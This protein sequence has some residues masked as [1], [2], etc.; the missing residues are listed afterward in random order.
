MKLSKIQAYFFILLAMMGICL[1]YQGIWLISGSTT[2]EIIK[3]GKGSG[4][5]YKHI[6]NVTVRYIVKNKSYTDTYL[7]NGLDYGTGTVPIKYLLFAPSISR[8]DNIIG[9]WGLVTVVFTIVFFILSIS[10]LIQDIVP[11]GSNFVFS[12]AYPFLR[13]KKP[14]TRLDVN[15]QYAW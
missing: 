15:D 8:Q 9:N 1:L 7:R 2:G 6:D 11:N 3:F 12:R 10:F 13:I 14:D 4:K 5:D